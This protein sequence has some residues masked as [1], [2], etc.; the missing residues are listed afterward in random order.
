M[1]E[2]RSLHP[3]AL[4]PYWVV[5]VI[6]RNNRYESTLNQKLHVT[7]VLITGRILNRVFFNSYR[8]SI[9]HF[10]GFLAYHRYYVVNGG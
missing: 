9:G 4:L 1:Q 2:C 3:T 10:G 7:I 6:R 8:V 5:V